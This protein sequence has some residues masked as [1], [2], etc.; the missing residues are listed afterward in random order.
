[1]NIQ[2]TFRKLSEPWSDRPGEMSR[3][4]FQQLRLLPLY[5][6]DPFNC[7]INALIGK[8]P[9][10]NSGWRESLVA[11]GFDGIEAGGAGGGVESG[12]EADDDRESDGA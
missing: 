3:L 9:T 11:E 5:C 7:L 6:A 2:V 10:T 8:W 1:M 12:D 4:R